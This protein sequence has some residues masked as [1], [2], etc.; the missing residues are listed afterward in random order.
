MTTLRRWC[1]SARAAAWH[2]PACSPQEQRHSVIPH[3]L[4]YADDP[5]L[6]T[7]T[8]G[9]VYQALRDITGKDLPN[10]SSILEKLV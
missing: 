1:A 8:H 3:L 10:D 6:D 4:D 9:W 7:Q 2:N 5:S